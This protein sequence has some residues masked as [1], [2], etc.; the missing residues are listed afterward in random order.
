MMQRRHTPTAW[1]ANDIT[2][3]CF[4]PK[5]GRDIADIHPAALRFVSFAHDWPSSFG[6]CLAWML[7]SSTLPHEIQETL[8]RYII[9][10]LGHGPSRIFGDEGT[11]GLPHR[12]KCQRGPNAGKA[13]VNR[14]ERDRNQNRNAWPSAV[15][16]SGVTAHVTGFENIWIRLRR[17][18]RY[19][20]KAIIALVRVTLRFKFA[21]NRWR[22]IFGQAVFSYAGD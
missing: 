22:S 19:K 4:S 7:H 15:H 1:V 11:H 20:K 3:S 21:N 10:Q 9:A 5:D 2:Q 14:A 6:N 8:E 13:D 17:P 12:R 16:K 18:T